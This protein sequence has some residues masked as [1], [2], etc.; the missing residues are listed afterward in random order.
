MSVIEKETREFYQ[1]GFPKKP[2][3]NKYNLKI[4]KRLKSARNRKGLSSAAVVREL[5]KQGISVGHS[6]L[7]GYEADEN[8]ANHRYP[9]LTT[10]MDLA[11]FYD[12]SV[13]YLLGVSDKFKRDNTKPREVD[14]FDLLESRNKLFYN[15]VELD[16]FQ[17]EM[18]ISHLDKLVLEQI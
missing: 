16:D 2:V 6:S 8:S 4:N 10:L 3:R 17:R 15:G 1:S 7:Q 12:C 18:I 9:S 5:K 13:D 14:V 11:T